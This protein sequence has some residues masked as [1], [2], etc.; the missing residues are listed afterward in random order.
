MCNGEPCSEKSDVWA[1]GCLLYE[2]ITMRRA[3][4]GASLPA[5]VA[6][7]LDR[8]P[9]LPARC[10]SPVRTLVHSMLEPAPGQ[11][12]SVDAILKLPWLRRYLE[13]YANQMMALSTSQLAAAP[14][15]RG[16]PTTSDLQ[17][18]PCGTHAVR[19][20]SHDQ[21][22][23][24]GCAP[25]V[26]ELYRG[27]DAAAPPSASHAPP[28]AAIVSGAELPS[29]A[30]QRPLEHDTRPSEGGRSQPGVHRLAYG[31]LH[32]ALSRSQMNLSACGP[33]H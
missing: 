7:I 20:R 4:E 14:T 30:T 32:R 2:M 25:A 28:S 13:Q 16:Q 21:V 5:V 33:R 1:L 31:V 22:Q 9:R 18:E 26:H 19:M 27:D 8:T 24:A 11:R 6:K 15:W 10:S 29:R 3:F 23:A 17:A 12:P